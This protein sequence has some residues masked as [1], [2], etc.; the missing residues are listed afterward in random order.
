MST[1]EKTEAGATTRSSRPQFF[2]FGGPIPPGRP[3]YVTRPVDAQLMAGVAGG[4]FINIVGA[5]QTG[6]SS[7]LL[8]A[9]EALRG[10]HA[11]PAVA[12]IDL[13]QQA[14]RDG[15]Q[16]AARWFYAIAYRLARQLRVGFDLQAWWSDHALMS[17]HHRFVELLRE[18]ALASGQRQVVL[19]FDDIHELLG[20]DSGEQLLS[21]FR[22]AFDARATDPEL[23]RLV[24]VMAGNGDG[25]FARASTAHSPYTVATPLA[26]GNMTLG[27]TLRLAP[28]L[29]FAR[30]QAELAMQR[31][32]DWVAGQP[33][34]TQYLASQLAVVDVNDD[35]VQA[36]DRIVQRRFE[37]QRDSVAHAPLLA[38]EAQILNAPADLRE[39]MLVVVGRIAKQ[40]RMLLDPANAAHDRLLRSGVLAVS[41]DG[42]LIPSSRL[43]RRYFNAGWANQHLPL[44]FG[45]LI[46]GA[47]LAL[48][49][50]MVPLWYRQY[51]PQPHVQAMTDRA[52]T[53][54]QLI[55]QYESFSRWPGYEGT[56]RRL[57]RLRLAEYARAA[58][59]VAALNSALLPLREQLGE[60][61]Q[62]DALA[63][64]FWT[65]QR[66]L[67]ERNGDRAGAIWAL[68]Q[69]LDYLG[70]EA[71]RSLQGLVSTDLPDLPGV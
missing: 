45:G 10:Q 18:F 23:A 19:L 46:K 63:G 37:Q 30:Q 24:I 9:A 4:T 59:N 60:T 7:L 44:R 8:H 26:I 69:G 12:F 47:V 40:Q 14:Q 3:G 21:A 66:A 68:L 1:P 17:H 62:A 36:V 15:Y 70:V 56:A 2:R 33:A 71:R 27:E 39:R 34:L 16:D 65:R 67:A 32:F 51:L 48:L 50:L 42:Y 58:D 6:K 49:F 11:A 28:A 41:P 35:V 20:I 55:E 43:S 22:A 57:T 52:T 13:G 5:P 25:Q 38:V 61:Q 29:G 31:I 64:A 54:P 53:I